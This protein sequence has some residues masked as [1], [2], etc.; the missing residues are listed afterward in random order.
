M[1]ALGVAYRV[2]K[3][4]LQTSRGGKV[5]FVR[6]SK[7]KLGSFKLGLV[8]LIALSSAF[9][10]LLMTGLITRPAWMPAI[11][12]DLLFGLVVAGIFILMASFFRIARLYAYGLL[13]GLALASTPLF[14]EVTPWALN[15]GF[16]LAGLIVLVSGLAVYRRFL[17]TTQDLQSG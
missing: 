15:P 11:A 12:V 2:G 7:V 17:H 3:S 16:L 5:E 9:A 6:A 8:I 1:L 10:I 4:R 13:F 14:E